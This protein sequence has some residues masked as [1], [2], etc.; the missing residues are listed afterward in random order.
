MTKQQPAW[1]LLIVSVPTAGA[2]LRMRLWRSVKALGCAALRDGAY[3]LPDISNHGEALTDLAEQTNAEGGQAWVVDVVPR[4][5]EDHEAFRVLFSRKE[6]YANLAGQLTQARKELG[7]QS[8]NETAKTLK[9]LRKERDA[10]RR[11]DFFPNEASL[12]AEAAWEDFE[13][14]V[15]AML[16]ADEPQAEE[17]PIPQ[18]RIADFQERTW[19]TRRN[20]WVDRVASAWLIRSFI[21]PHARFLWLDSPSACP[22]GALGFDFEGAAFTHVGDKVTFEVLLASFSLDSDP[23]LSRLGALV[24]ALDVGGTVPPE[25][26]GF[27]AIMAGARAR[28]S[29]DDALLAEIGAVLDSLHFHFNKD[30]S[31]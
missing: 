17:R 24:H 8:P 23:A 19:A 18:L 7:V 16:T 2:T 20:L 3:L 12:A 6:D 9:R 28:L 14:A 30:R 22:E 27:E 13:D 11:I 29:D 26:S 31:Q 25:T 4:S 10:I 21:D 1:H 15:K 5:A